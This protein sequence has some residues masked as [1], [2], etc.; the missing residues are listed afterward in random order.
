MTVVVE[1]SGTPVALDAPMTTSAG[2][3]G[4][5]RGEQKSYRASRLRSRPDTAR[6][7]VAGYP[8]NAQPRREHSNH[9]TASRRELCKDGPV[10][11]MACAGNGLIGDLSDIA[12][13]ARSVCA[14]RP[15]IFLWHCLSANSSAPVLKLSRV[16]VGSWFECHSRSCALTATRALAPT[17]TYGPAAFTVCTL[18][19]AHALSCASRDHSGIRLRTC[20]ASTPDRQGGRHGA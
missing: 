6:Y 19:P 12:I 13:A 18:R 1:Q 2:S 14:P 4:K 17:R 9:G 8:G 7:M 16:P 11:F 3:R 15:A 5:R 20:P 10:G